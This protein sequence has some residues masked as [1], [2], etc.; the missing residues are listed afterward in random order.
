MRHDTSR[1]LSSLIPLSQISG[2]ANMLQNHHIAF[3]WW[4]AEMTQ[5]RTEEAE[6]GRREGE[7]SGHT[8]R[9]RHLSVG[10]ETR[11]EE[12][13]ATLLD[14]LDLGEVSPAAPVATNLCPSFPH[15]ILDQ[16]QVFCCI[17]RVIQ[18]ISKQILVS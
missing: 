2:T 17:F 3:D 8:L 9:L 16:A 5:R 1:V 12:L 7:F 18:I 6:T 4:Q 15:L 11:A 10:R 13:A 14:A